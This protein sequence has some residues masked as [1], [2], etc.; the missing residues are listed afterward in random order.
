MTEMIDSGINYDDL[1]EVKAGRKA[2][3]GGG[4]VGIIDD[5]DIFNMN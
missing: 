2:V 3:H 4:M 5:E 1:Q